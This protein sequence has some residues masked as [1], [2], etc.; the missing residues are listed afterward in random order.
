MC[1]ILVVTMIA[2]VIGAGIGAVSA[3]PVTN[4][5][6]AGQV[7]KMSNQQSQVEENFGRPGN[8]PQGQSLF[9]IHFPMVSAAF[10]SIWR[11]G[12]L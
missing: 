2:V 6:L 11:M 10:F 3:V 1:E 9:A 8:M 5:L 12:R 7:E 4:T